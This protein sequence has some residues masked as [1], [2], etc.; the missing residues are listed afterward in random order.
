MKL[1]KLQPYGQGYISYKEFIMKN[2]LVILALCGFASVSFAQ[3]PVKPWGEN[4]RPVA[5]KS[6]KG[7]CECKCHTEK[8]EK[9]KPIRQR[10]DFRKKDDKPQQERIQNH[11]KKQKR[12]Q[13]HRKKQK[14]GQ[15]HRKKQ[16]G[17]KQPLRKHFS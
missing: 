11:R 10:K 1:K 12:I 16:W 2:L 17:K 13:D 7:C 5:E 6:D 3:R 14:R 8:V 9:K 15:D 4:K